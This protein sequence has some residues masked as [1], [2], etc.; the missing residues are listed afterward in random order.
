MTLCPQEGTDD[1]C[2]CVPEDSA[3]RQEL[4]SVVIG[5]ATLGNWFPCCNVPTSGKRIP[6]LDLAVCDEHAELFQIHPDNVALE[7]PDA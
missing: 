3:R 2:A 6:V 7:G 1:T 5:T 4:C